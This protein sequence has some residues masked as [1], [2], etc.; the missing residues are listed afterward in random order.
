MLATS[1]YAV[2]RYRLKLQ[3]IATL[4]RQFPWQELLFAWAGLLFSRRVPPNGDESPFAREARRAECSAPRE[5]SGLR[6]FG[7][8]NRERTQSSLR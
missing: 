8:R 2:F 7:G 5:S 3:R 1:A 4:I 6:A